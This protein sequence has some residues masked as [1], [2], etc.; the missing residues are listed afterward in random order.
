MATGGRANL[1]ARLYSAAAVECAG[2]LY[3][4]VRAKLEARCG[5]QYQDPIEQA[6]REWEAVAFPVTLRYR[7]DVEKV[8]DEIVEK[9]RGYSRPAASRLAPM[10]RWTKREL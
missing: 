5:A 7:E 1:R 9:R 10:V 6:R 4:Y 8:V 3:L 2:G